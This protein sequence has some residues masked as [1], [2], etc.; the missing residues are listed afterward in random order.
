MYTIARPGGLG[1][2]PLVLASLR[3]TCQFLL[4]GTHL[5]RNSDVQ[6]QADHEGRSDCPED[7]VQQ[8]HSCAARSNHI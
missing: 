7:M 4:L 6:H 3:E 2:G 5:G 8:G 1:P